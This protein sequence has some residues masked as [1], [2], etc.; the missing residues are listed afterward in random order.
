[1]SCKDCDRQQDTNGGYYIR[2]GNGNVYIQA[3]QKHF[4]ELK[5]MV[6]AYTMQ[7]H[8]NADTAQKTTRNPNVTVS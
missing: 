1:M 7:P 8:A 4:V 5:T 6:R 2:I 3:C